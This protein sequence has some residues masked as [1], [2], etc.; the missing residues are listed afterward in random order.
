VT[1]LLEFST[2]IT[3]LLAL[4]LVRV[5]VG[6]AMIAIGL[7]GFS[8]EAGIGPGL[9]VLQQAI[10]H[11][12]TD[13]LFAVIPLFVLMGSL[14]LVSDIS[15]EL[16]DASNAWLGHKRGG[17][18][19]SSMMA[20]G[21]FA[22]ICGSSVA[23]AATM[24]KVALPAMKERGYPADFSGA[25]IAAGGT[26]G[27][28]IPPSV[29]LALYGVLVETDIAALF[30]A[31]IVPGI[32]ALLFYMAAIVILG[33]LNPALAP[34]MEK[35]SRSVAIRKLGKIWAAA[36]L[37]VLV[38]GGIYLGWFTPSEAAAVGVCGLI[39]IGLLRGKLN[40]AKI[41]EALTDTAATTGRIFLVIIGA[42]VFSRYLA[43][44]QVT[45][46]LSAF[47]TSLDMLP[48]AILLLILA[49][50]LVMGAFLDALAVIVLT[51]PVIHPIIL[52][53]GFSEIWFGII[54]VMVVEL[55][56]ITPPYGMNV[57]VLRSVAPDVPIFGV[58]RR[59][60]PF[61]LTDIIRLVLFV[62]IPAIVLFLPEMIDLG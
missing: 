29:V 19:L 35:V 30:A 25:I 18:A 34:S 61:I 21:G 14:A 22:A 56:L 4:L 10:F 36:L 13:E 31:A 57:F 55:G 28:L 11:A 6:I 53:L 32:L 5:P 47:I 26:L 42:I 40:V 48:I 12:A 33:A 43:V 49:F 37:F 8:L 45:Q 59:L 2:A 46:D 54:L 62:A 7:V 52:E 60:L 51:V 41:T 23:S 58:F 20:C 3:L 38:I 24:G 27:V 39:A 50:Y 44:N 17:L 1:S 15:D 16:F 9:A